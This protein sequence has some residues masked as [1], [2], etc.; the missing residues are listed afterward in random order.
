MSGSDNALCALWEQFP[1]QFWQMCVEQARAQT[2]ARIRGRVNT[3]I[4]KISNSSFDT[5]LSF[6]A[7]WVGPAIFLLSFVFTKWLRLTH[8]SKKYAIR[9]QNSPNLPRVVRSLVMSL[10]WLN[11]W[12]KTDTHCIGRGY[13][14]LKDCVFALVLDVIYHGHVTAVFLLLNISRQFYK[15]TR[16]VLSLLSAKFRFP[17]RYYC[18]FHSSLPPLTSLAVP[19]CRFLAKWQR[20]RHTSA[21][22]FFSSRKLWRRWQYVQWNSGGQKCSL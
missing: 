16:P 18:V 20:G 9:A 3:S 11:D 6:T 14:S 10:K 19:N 1:N 22:A 15:I 2:R 5:L 12:S 21:I 13:L 4:S 17:A 8:A 7:W